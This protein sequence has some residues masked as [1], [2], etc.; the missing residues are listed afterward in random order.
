[1]NGQGCVGKFRSYLFEGPSEA[2]RVLMSVENNIKKQKKDRYSCGN[3]CHGVGGEVSG[4]AVWENGC[5]RTSGVLPPL[6]GML[7]CS[8]TVL[9]M[10]IL[11]ATIMNELGVHMPESIHSGVVPVLW[12]ERAG[13]C[14]VKT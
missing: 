10:E 3:T 11:R 14:L 13:F 5:G 1:M 8:D 4:K 12:A 6:L 9:A 7:S 2:Q